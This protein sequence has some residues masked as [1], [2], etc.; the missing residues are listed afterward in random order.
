MLPLARGRHQEGSAALGRVILR[1]GI[2]RVARGDERSGARPEQMEAS[3][4]ARRDSAAASAAKEEATPHGS[5][6][7]GAGEPLR[8]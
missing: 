3:S 6:S 7:R 4:F 8:I 5:A 1:S 2:R